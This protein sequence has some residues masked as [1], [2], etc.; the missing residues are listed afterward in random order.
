MIFLWA[1]IVGGLICVIGQLLMD[2]GKLTPAHTMSSLVVAG[3]VLDGVGLYEPLI[4]FAGAGA[5]V[6]ITSFGNALV[7][8]A[9]SEAQRNGIIGVITGIFEVTSAGISSAII[10]GFIAALLFKP[11]G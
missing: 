10:F 11:K 6:P 1:F 8:G 3:A 7:H 4:D 2:V 9:I 5:T